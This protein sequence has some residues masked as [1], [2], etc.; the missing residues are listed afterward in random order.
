MKRAERR[1]MEAALK[2]AWL[3]RLRPATPRLAQWVP[4]EWVNWLAPRLA[5]NRKRRWPWGRR[6]RR[7]EVKRQRREGHAIERVGERTG[8]QD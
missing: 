8:E 1:R 7:G 5:H 6:K 3:R 4:E 2:L